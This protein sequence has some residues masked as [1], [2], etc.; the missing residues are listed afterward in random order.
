MMKNGLV[1]NPAPDWGKLLHQVPCLVTVQIDPPRGR[2]LSISESLVKTGNGA[3]SG[4]IER[5][6]AIHGVA[7]KL[8]R[9]PIISI[10]GQMNGGKSSVLSSFLSPDGASRVPVGNGDLQ[11][12]HRFV[13]WLPSAWRVDGRAGQI[14]ELVTKGHGRPPQEL[15]R[16]TG[17][18]HRQYNSGLDNRELLL[19]PLVAF[20]ERLGDYAFLD[21]PDFQSY[22]S[23]HEDR[24]RFVVQSA[25]LCSAFLFVL[26]QEG[27]RD[28]RFQKAIMML[29]ESLPGAKLYLLV[30]KIVPEA[31]Q[32]AGVASEPSLMNL[33]GPARVRA[34]YGAL[35]FMHGGGEGWPGWRDLTPRALQER[36]GN[37]RV[38]HFFRIF[39]GTQGPDQPEF[40]VDLPS[41]GGLDPAELQV[42]QV[43]STVASIQEGLRRARLLVSQWAV[44]R[45]ARVRGL[46]A[47]LL[48]FCASEI[49]SDKDGKPLQLPDPEFVPKLEDAIIAQAPFYLRWGLK[50]NRGAGKAAKAGRDLAI[51]FAKRVRDQIPLGRAVGKLVDVLPTGDS[52]GSIQLKEFDSQSLARKMANDLR[53]QSLE[54]EPSKEETMR[55]AW[56][57]VFRGAE[58]FRAK[59][60][61]DQITKLGREFWETIPKSTKVKMIATTNLLTLFGAIGALGAAMVAP[62]D[63]GA[64]LFGTLSLQTSLYS[65][66]LPLGAAGGLLLGGTFTDFLISLTELVTLPQLSCVF[67]LACDAF[68]LPR[69]I[70]GRKGAPEPLVVTFGKPG[71]ESKEFK[72]PEV[73]LVRGLP[74]LC[75]LADG[76]QWVVDD[77][78]AGSPAM[79]G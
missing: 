18:A 75:P 19:T 51:Q 8:S 15:S 22:E 34:A 73:D 24:L 64:T 76:V 63:G 1:Q 5:L 38:P 28:A 59:A 45:D 66:V 32:P 26:T 49:F 13:Y 16:D 46:H 20:D 10:M 69:R 27:I 78:L 72:L 9:C 29:R 35:N 60:D 74:I 54:E 68:G 44:E 14:I 62:V 7:Q 39:P 25:S 56:D 71:Q 55:E 30:N 77:D 42:A 61:P 23:A 37:P 41:S 58:Y 36:I 67:T 65:A 57:T 52:S 2:V 43:Q 4:E 17:E 21:C 40:L 50:M 31:G 79:G 3:L 53:L 11:G 12:T 70:L 6:V 47:A 33:A 48:E